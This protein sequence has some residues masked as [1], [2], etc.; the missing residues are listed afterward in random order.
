MSDTT[1][2]PEITDDLGRILPRVTEDDLIRPIV[3]GYATPR[4]ILQALVMAAQYGDDAAYNRVVEAA[5]EAGI[6]H[7]PPDLAGRRYPFTQVPI[8]ED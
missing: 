1:V 5:H 3:D 8:Y 4:T 6:T 7:G 2:R